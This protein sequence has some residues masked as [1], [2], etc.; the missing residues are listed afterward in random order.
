MYIET[1]FEPRWSRHHGNFPPSL[2]PGILEH[3]IIASHS[4]RPSYIRKT[5]ISVT[6]P[7]ENNWTIFFFVTGNF[8]F[9]CPLFAPLLF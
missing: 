1:G 8:I 4:I 6:E 3:N 7:Y 5:F 2:P 9:F